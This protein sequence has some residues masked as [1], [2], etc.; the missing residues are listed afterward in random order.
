MSVDGS[1][2][3][4]ACTGM[5]KWHGCAGKDEDEKWKRFWR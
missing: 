4:A 3:T 1:H 5:V 2:L